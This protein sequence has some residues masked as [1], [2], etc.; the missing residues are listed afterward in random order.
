MTSFLRA[1][2]WTHT[3]YHYIK[4]TSVCQERISRSAPIF[5]EK[6]KESAKKE[7]QIH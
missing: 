3:I 2:L 1:S 6:R 5:S 7:K 4:K